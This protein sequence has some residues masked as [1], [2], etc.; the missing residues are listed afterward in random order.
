VTLHHR[1]R[2]QLFRSCPSNLGHGGDKSKMCSL[3]N[4]KQ[5][6]LKKEDLGI[7]NSQAQKEYSGNGS[8]ILK[9]EK[10]GIKKTFVDSMPAISQST[11]P[12]FNQH[13]PTKQTETKLPAWTDFQQDML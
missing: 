1:L 10:F 6:N 2:K 4:V 3:Q 12:A 5:S 9:H 11:N 7:I 13:K 8:T